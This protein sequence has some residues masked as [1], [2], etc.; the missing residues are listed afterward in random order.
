MQ[1]QREVIN[2]ARARFEQKDFAGA[3]DLYRGLVE[4]SPSSADLRVMLGMCRFAQG[5]LG[6]ALT[7][8]ETAAEL[9]D[10]RA[11]TWFHLARVH[12]AAGDRKN[13]RAAIGRCIERNPNHVLGRL[14]SGH[15]ALLENNPGGAEQA[16]RTALRADPQS[17]PAQ[18]ALGELLL[19][20]GQLDEAHRYASEALKLRPTEVG[21]QLLMARVFRAQGHHAFAERALL[22]A[23]EQRPRQREFRIELAGLLYDSNRPA[24]ALEALR[25]AGPGTSSAEIALLRELGQAS[26]ARRRLET[27][28]ESESSMSTDATA[29]LA[30]LRLA[31]GDLDGAEVL[32]R[33]LAAERPEVQQ[34]IEALIAE[35]RAQV[36]QAVKLARGLFASEDAHRQRQARLLVARLS[37]AGGDAETCRAALDPLV[38]KHDDPTAHSL[39]AQSLDRDGQTEQAAF[40]LARS[41]WRDAAIVSELGRLMPEAVR[42][43]VRALTETDWPPPEFNPAGRRVVHLLGWPAGAR[44]AVLAA[45][46]AHPGIKPMPTGD[47]PRRREILRLPV[48]PS[49]LVSYQP[50][51]LERILKR[52]LSAAGDDGQRLLLETVGLEAVALPAVARS[53]P[54]SKVLMINEDLR[55]LE[56]AWRMAGF[57][58]AASMVSLW[59][60]ERELVLQLQTFLPLEFIRIDRAALV[61]DPDAAL[62]RLATQLDLDAA[63]TPDMVT[64][65]RAEL[66][67]LRPTGAWAAY[68]NRLVS[69][70]TSV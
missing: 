13:A 49:K 41:G 19:E 23:I 34:L 55:D 40:H 65:A 5:D 54:G 16:Y 1:T 53:L 58:N 43:E 63:A 33:T 3:E 10:D 60:Q 26:E 35:Q 44:P 61:A 22:N 52:Y 15:L 20:Q 37:L 50:M 45:L 32:A 17:V 42:R 38:E 11:E 21:A 18:I 47:L 57:R 39:L 70:D 6:T 31:S 62:A 9:D 2:Q 48:T 68:R 64:A 7:E 66:A 14:E 46:T 8:L 59:K 67:A 30:E 24:E 28:Y 51:Q 29:S 36:D 12:R 25:S 4:D 56:L 69:A 27:W